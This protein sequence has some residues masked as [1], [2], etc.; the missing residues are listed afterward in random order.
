MEGLQQPKLSDEARNGFAAAVASQPAEGTETP[1]E[2]QEPVPAEQ[3]SPAPATEAEPSDVTPTTEEVTEATPPETGDEHSAEETPKAPVP[4]DRFKQVNDDKKRLEDQVKRLQSTGGADPAL[5]QQ[6][7]EAQSRAQLA[8]IAASHPELQAAIF[9][10]QPG[11]PSQAPPAA[12]PLDPKDPAHARIMATEAALKAVQ[13]QLSAQQ[14]QEI[15]D[16]MQDRAET[17]MDTHAVFKHKTA[18]TIGET[19]IAQRLIQNPRT[20]VD[21]V[22]D[23]VAK[24]VRELTETT[25]A[26]YVQA[27]VA[28]AKKIAPGVGG[29]AAPP[30][31]P[32]GQK[33]SLKDGSAR[34][35][36][37]AALRRDQQQ[38]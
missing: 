4:Y 5:I 16:D 1:V 19:L 35:G 20:P 29:G 38:G 30:G 22:V 28:P 37:E 15:I 27:K 6:M 25:K 31:A 18:R 23:D 9:G 17:R 14:R 7:V 26:A 33:Y 2:T 11:D 36:L 12:P 10:D 8:R 34:K 13:S 32:V 21:A 3:P 24:M